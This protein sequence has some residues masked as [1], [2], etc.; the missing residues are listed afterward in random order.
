VKGLLETLPPQQLAMFEA[1]G[2]FKASEYC[3]KSNRQE[4]E[5][6]ERDLCALS[7]A[8]RKDALVEVKE[9]LLYGEIIEDSQEDKRGHSCLV[10]GL[11]HPGKDIHVSCGQAF[12]MLWVIRCM[13]RMLQNGSNQERGGS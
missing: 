7:S 10:Y 6:L 11:S 8:S 2:E 13:N 4:E 1:A 9:A 3:P 5:W 12:D